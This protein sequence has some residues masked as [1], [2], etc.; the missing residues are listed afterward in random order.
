MLTTHKAR[1]YAPIT[2]EDLN[3]VPVT[4]QGD[5]SDR[6]QGVQHGELVQA[7]A[8]GFAEAGMPPTDI[9]LAVQKTGHAVVGG[10]V[11]ETPPEARIEALPAMDLSVGFVSCNNSRVAMRGAIGSEVR[12]C[13]N[14]M[15]TG[16]FTWSRKHTNGANL[17][18]W[19]QEGIAQYQNGLQ[20]HTRRIGDLG[21]VEFDRPMA[22]EAIVQLA[23]R[24]AISWKNA[25]KVYRLWERPEFAEFGRETAFNFYQAF[26]S[27]VKELPMQD[28]FSTLRNGFQVVEEVAGLYQGV[29]ERAWDRGV[30]MPTFPGEDLLN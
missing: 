28:Q 3:R 20:E 7:V 12:V 14:G 21:E 23:S 10:M 19:V 26:N 6:W 22:N 24:N 13:G 4:E 1:G 16:E 5:R 11:L 9:R 27:V 17:Q 2:M 29:V 18:E 25:G 15:C 30:H 8:D